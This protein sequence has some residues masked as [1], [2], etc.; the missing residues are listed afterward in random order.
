MEKY[1]VLGTNGTKVIAV[2]KTDKSL[3]H[4]RTDILLKKNTL[5]DKIYRLSVIK[6]S[7]G[8]KIKESHSGT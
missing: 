4:Y 7:I 3:G 2:N 1:Y 5:A 8:K 6:R